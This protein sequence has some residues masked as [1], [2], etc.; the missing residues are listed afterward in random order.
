MRLLL[1]ALALL[2]ARPGGAAAEPTPRY[3]YTLHCAGC[4]KLD[5]SG[6]NVVPA[7]DEI[8]LVLAAGGRNYL[9]RV[10]G[11]AQAP[12]SDRRLAAL[13]N[14]LLPRFGNTNAEPPY[15]A[16]E[17][18]RLRAAPLRDP[19]AARETLFAG[20]SDPVD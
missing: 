15:S 10:P 14:W 20:P 8:G 4:H 9:V 16:A 13:M 7:L 17:V 5:G 11:A 2:A 19:V 12:L 3:D 1:V 18:R 6:S